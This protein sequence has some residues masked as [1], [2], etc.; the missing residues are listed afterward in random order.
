ML[1]LRKK[2]VRII[3]VLFQNQDFVTH[4]ILFP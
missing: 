3:L 2:N 1:N 4:T